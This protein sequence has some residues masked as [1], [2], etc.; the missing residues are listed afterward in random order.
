MCVV[1]LSN[2]APAEMA[3]MLGKPEGEVGRAVGEMFNRVNAN[4]TSAVYQRL[5]LRDND[6][7]LEIGFGNGRLL[8]A[9]MALA[10]GLTYVG[11]DRAK[12]MVTE[13]TAHNAELVAAARASFRLGS[14]EAIP[15]KD[16]SFDRVFAVNVV[17]FWPDPVRAL[18]EMRRVLRPGGLSIVAS[19][20]MA[21]GEELPAYA[22][23]E[24]GFHRR[25]R[26]TLL[27][28]HRDAGFS[29]V[30][31]DDY[32]EMAPLPD[33]STRKRSYAIIL[34]RP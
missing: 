29:N 1:D 11:L 14:A 32:N 26:E 3:G 16:E 6:R 17:Y 18:A 24:Y 34:A 25:S 28:L 31:V 12:T 13:A 2:L 21:P 27:A 23:P 22:K 7:V 33:G 10:D 9:L 30:L 15:C 20:V 4:I 19:V 8:S 5:M